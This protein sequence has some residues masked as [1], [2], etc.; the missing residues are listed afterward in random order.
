[1][2]ELAEIPSH[3]RK[4]IDTF[5]FEEVPSLDY[6]SQS[7]R[8]EKLKGYPDYFKARFGSYRVGMKREGDTLVFER[9]MH[10]KDI[11]RYFP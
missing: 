5:V 10:R 3:V 8:I 9:V 11:Y 1:M 6:I 4:V 2:K 7:I